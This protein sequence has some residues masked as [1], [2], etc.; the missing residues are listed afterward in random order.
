MN[1]W[2][3]CIV[4]ILFCLVLSFPFSAEAASSSAVTSTFEST[5]LRGE[6]FSGQNLQ[7]AEFTKVNL[8]GA[9]LSNSD[10]RGA[11]F[12]GTSAS[13]VNLH[14]A[15]LTNGLTYVSSFNEADLT[16]AVFREAM[17]LRTT[18]NGAKI[19]GAD[20]TYAILDGEQVSKLCEY[21]SGI[22]SQTGASTRQ[23]LGCP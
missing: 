8:E 15:D 10:L 20:F 1:F 6:D 14:G 22:N 18:F 5:D 4:I 17:M 19:E 9:N 12:N 2:K 13:K 16:D 21:A 3:S 11:V 7:L 23:S